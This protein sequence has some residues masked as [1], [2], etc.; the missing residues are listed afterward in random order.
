MLALAIGILLF[1]KG[2]EAYIPIYI[3]QLSQVILD[4]VNLGTLE[5]EIRLDYVFQNGAVLF[6]FLIANYFLDLLTLYLKTKVGQK[7]IFS[8]RLQVFEHIQKM[9]LT[10][11]NQIPV[12]TLMTRTIH[13][14]DQIN[15]MFTES[16]VPLIGSLFLFLCIIVGSAIYDWKLTLVLVIVT[17]IMFWMT[18]YFRIHQ[19]ICYDKIRVIV[20]SMNAFVQ[21][22]LMG[23]ATIRNFGLQKQ[24]KVQ[25]EE[26]NENQR[27]AYVETI[28]YYSLFFSQIDF[29]QSFALIM[30]FLVLVVFAPID[31]GFQA[32]SYF[33]FSLYIVMLFRPLS[34]LADRYNVLQAA[35]AA[36]SRIFKILDEPIETSGPISGRELKSIDSIEFQDV[37]SAYKDEQWVLK[38]VTFSVQKGESIALVGVTGE[39]KT[40]IINL[41]LRFYEFQKGTIKIN[42]YDIREYTV[43]S[44]RKQFNIVLQDPEIFSGTIADNITM[45]NPAVTLEKVEEVSRFVKLTSVIKRYPEG[46]NYYL[47]ERGK[48]LSVGER[49]LVSLARAVAHPGSVLIFDEAT[50]NIDTPTEHIIQETLKSILESKTAIVIA[51]RLSTIKDVNRILVIHR[52]KIVESGTHKELLEAKGIYEKLYRLQFK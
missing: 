44:L 2:I 22:R 25:F 14:I 30:I 28:Q 33:T 29:M 11:F 12:G 49:Q 39:G 3:G 24:E 7:A 21:E 16:L 13:D 4:S 31:V 20:A 15:E 47:T 8:F 43:A 1:S 50:A 17:P 45:F 26:I 27:K 42:G 40:T 32:G 6:A 5:K 19:R 48:G 18:N 41:L 37:W 51:H 10:I 9:P 38:G 23:A 35:M 36:G 52:G 46:M 34:E